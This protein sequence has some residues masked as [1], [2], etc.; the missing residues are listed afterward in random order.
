MDAFAVLNSAAT[1]SFAST[2]GVSIL[3]LSAFSKDVVNIMIGSPL[4]FLYYNMP[5]IIA[6]GM[7]SLIL[8]VPIGATAFYRNR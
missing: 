4:T 7:I 6:Y 2:T 5:S 3:S 8:I 1:S